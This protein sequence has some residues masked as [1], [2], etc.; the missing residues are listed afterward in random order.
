MGGNEGLAELGAGCVVWVDGR[1]RRC[2]ALSGRGWRCGAYNN[3]TRD[4]EI[5][6]YR[7]KAY[8]LDTYRGKYSQLPCGVAKWL[9]YTRLSGYGLL[10]EAVGSNLEPC[11]LQFC[12][13]IR[14]P[15]S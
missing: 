4:L 9:K 7:I 6:K 2:S 1:Q 10:L 14:T 5:A 12:L 15:C 13:S 3:T 8:V 11:Y